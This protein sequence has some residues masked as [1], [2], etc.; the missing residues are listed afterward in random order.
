MKNILSISCFLIFSFCVNAQ[1]D[2][3][4]YVQ[5]PAFLAHKKPIIVV[6]D[7]VNSKSSWIPNIVVNVRFHIV[8][9]TDGSGP[10][11]NYAEA[12]VMNAMKILNESFYRKILFKYRGFDVIQNNTYTNVAQDVDGIYSPNQ[13]NQS[14]FLGLIYHSKTM[15]NPVHTTTALNIYIVQ[16]VTQVTT[17][18]AGLAVLNGIEC[19]LPYQ[20][21]LSSSLPHEVAHNFGLYHTHDQMASSPLNGCETVSGA[22]V[23]EVVPSTID[24]QVSALYR[25][26]LV[27]D[28]PASYFFSNVNIGTNCTFVPDAVPVLDCKGNAYGANGHEIPIKNFMSRNNNCRGLGNAFFTP[29]Q[30]NRMRAT[31]NGT[32]YATVFNPIKNTVASLYRPYAV[33]TMPN[34]KQQHKFQ[35][36]FTYSFPQ[37]T[38]PDLV[39]YTPNDLPININYASQYCIQISEIPFQN[40]LVYCAFQVPVNLPQQSRIGAP[41]YF[42][43]GTI[44]STVDLGSTNF[45]TRS[46]TEQEANDINFADS[47]S[48]NLYH[49]IVRTADDGT[50]DRKTIYKK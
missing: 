36:G 1:I 12:E 46:I 43:G 4:G 38:A 47:L 25:G 16:G 39:S 30:M 41:V 15:P 6:G 2:C 13:P 11:Q 50:T 5:N 49:I 3:G 20:Q 14:T 45:V 9:N 35:K 29:G 17:P 33:T 10:L 31:L 18:I 24:V 37:A 23:P 22:Y 7:A 42:T 27:E 32:I 8:K 48:S 44:T 19:V 21:F 40:A 26:D 28:T 34:G